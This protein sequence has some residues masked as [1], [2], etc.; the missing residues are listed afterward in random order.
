MGQTFCGS[1]VYEMFNV[2]SAV[3]SLS[4]LRNAEEEMLDRR[5][6]GDAEVQRL[7]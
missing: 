1:S 2:Y 7:P 3:L 5:W 4:L 6:T